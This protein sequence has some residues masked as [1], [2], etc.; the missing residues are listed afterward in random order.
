MK[1]SE[2]N[3]HKKIHDL[4]IV[5]E[6]LSNTGSVKPHKH[7]I[8]DVLQLKQELNDI[9]KRLDDLENP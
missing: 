1:E 5:V 3:I 4:E 9:K 6:N 2:K 8:N 7:E